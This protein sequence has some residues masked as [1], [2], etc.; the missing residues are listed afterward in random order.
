M[1][2]TT[3]MI[4]FV[5]CLILLISL[6]AGC[7]EEKDGRQ[8]K[9]G[10]DKTAAADTESEVAATS[11]SAAQTTAGPAAAGL[12]GVTVGKEPGFVMDM[13]AGFRFS[14]DWHAYASADNSVYIFGPDITFF[15]KEDNFEDAASLIKGERR[16]E[17]IGDFAA[18]VIE[19]PDSFYG[20]CTHYYLRLSPITDRF[21]GC[22]LM[23]TTSTGEF[24]DT[25]TEAIKAA[26]A[27]L[28]R[29]DG[30][31]TGE[32]KSTAAD[33]GTAATTAQTA[34]APTSAFADLKINFTPDQT[35]RMSNFMNAGCYAVEAD[36]VYGQGF[37]Q[38]GDSELVKFTLTANGDVADGMV[39]DAAAD[40]RY[41]TLYGDYIYYLRNAESIYRIGKDGNNPERVV[42]GAADYFQIVGDKLYFADSDYKLKS[43]DV[44]GGNVTTVLDKEVYYAYFIAPDWLIYQDDAD[45]ETLHLRYMPTGED[46]RLSAHIANC[47]IIV[48]S[49]LFCVVNE[50]GR[51]VLAKVQLGPVDIA[52][53]TEQYDYFAI[54][55]GD[56]QVLGD[57]A[58][59]EDG[60]IYNGTD[61]GRTVDDWQQVENT[62]EAAVTI[63]RY[64]GSDYTIYWEYG[65]DDVVENIYLAVNATGVAEPLPRFE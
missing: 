57:L 17:K 65:A 18:L 37:N 15:E 10:T 40:P 61:Q 13:P 26:V 7:G 59:T 16:E 32:D 27:S 3:R 41:V 47:P 58:I 1:K 2:T 60:Y 23:V 51:Q 29:A 53:D 9:T 54:E 8:D 21:Y 64:S 42:D 30:E 28:R 31:A 62:A 44:D 46:T 35:A 22:Q 24:R 25:Q 36:T 6:I 63:Y 20:K 43:A 12:K 45:G 38:S 19:E 55:L 11:A 5:L 34:D 56:K 50:S 49:E 48:G 52:G 39:L 14:D 33:S 4:I